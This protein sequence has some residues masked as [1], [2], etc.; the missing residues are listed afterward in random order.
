LPAQWE[1]GS[2]GEGGIWENIFLKMS[3]YDIWDP[4]FENQMCIALQARSRVR[5][6]LKNAVFAERYYVYAQHF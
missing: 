2:G 6:L 5:I 3:T 4:G 1:D